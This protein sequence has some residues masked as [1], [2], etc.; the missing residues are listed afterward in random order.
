MRS[1]GSYCHWAVVGKRLEVV[2]SSDRDE[3]VGCYFTLPVGT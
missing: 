3:L 2:V 1:N